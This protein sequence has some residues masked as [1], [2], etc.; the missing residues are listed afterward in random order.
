MI[1]NEISKFTNIASEWWNLHGPF[2]LLHEINPV[3]LEYVLNQITSFYNLQSNN[4]INKLK[5]LDVGCGGG[6]LTQPLARLGAEMHAIDAGE[7]NIKVAIE[8]AQEEDLN[9]NFKCCK[10]EQFVENNK[11]YDVVICLE[12]L[13]HVDDPEDFISFLAKALKNNGLLIVSTLNRTLKAKILAIWAAENI[14]KMV[15]KNTHQYNKFIKPSELKNYGDKNNLLLLDLTGMVLDL[16]TREWKL[17]PDL[18]INYFAS[19]KKVI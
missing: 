4:E 12:V 5:I 19:F 16:K 7:E 15:P 13:E 11:N 6:I 17:L 1:E 14:L 2:K 8:K 9:I 3:R 18:D 10:I